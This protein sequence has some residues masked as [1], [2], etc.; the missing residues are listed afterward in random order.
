[1]PIVKSKPLFRKPLLLRHFRADASQLGLGGACKL[2][3]AQGLTILMR[4]FGF[5]RREWRGE[6]RVPAL[7]HPLIFRYFS[8]DVYTIRQTLVAREHEPVSRLGALRLI[9]DCGA[10]IGA[11][12]ACLLSYYPSATLIAIEPDADNFAVLEKNLAPYGARARRFVPLFG[13]ARAKRCAAS[14][15]H[16]RTVSI[17]RNGEC[18]G[19][20]GRRISKA[21]P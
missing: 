5:R 6:L 16:S 15:A 9:V 13:R 17:G 1:M 18:G 19:G 20:P 4:D 12:A 14:V 2:L 3:V 21:L 8:S 11:S 10:N 7:A